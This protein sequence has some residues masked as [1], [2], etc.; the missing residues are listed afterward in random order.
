M[1]ILVECLVFSVWYL[2]FG[3]WCFDMPIQH[4]IFHTKNQTR[5]TKHLMNSVFYEFINFTFFVGRIPP[6]TSTRYG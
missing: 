5:N 2:V 3:V 4:H 6:T 1:K